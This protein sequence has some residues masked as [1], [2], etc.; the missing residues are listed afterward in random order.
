MT[1]LHF[2]GTCSPRSSPA[3]IL[4]R[5]VVVVVM[6]A[7]NASADPAEAIVLAT[8]DA[9]FQDALGDALA[10]GGISVVPAGDV[11]APS[12]AALSTAS[13]ELADRVHAT[14]TV[15][16]IASPG[17]A[18]LVAYDRERDRILVRQLPYPTP[19]APLQ[20]AEAARTART[21][22]RALRVTPD[23]DQQP[24]L[25]EDAPAIRDTVITRERP[26]LAASALV[27][28]RLGAPDTD[29]GGGVALAWRP[30][31]LGIALSAEL[32]PNADVVTASFTG[33]VIDGAI[34]LLGRAPLRVAPRINVVPD[35]GI[36]VH[37]FRLHGALDTMQP[38]H[39]TRYDP[40]ARV[41]VAATYR[42]GNDLD[43]GLAVSVDCLL[44]RQRYQAGD[45][46]VL[47]IPRLQTL[48]G[49]IATLRVL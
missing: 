1:A 35:V 37:V 14:A 23:V 33:T 18:T 17:G 40:A 2:K 38:I 20:A 9:V 11:P 28:I 48:V 30:D 16:L 10:A 46:Q 25:V 5:A 26:L 42:I 43:V 21:M 6:V 31:R 4:V 7:T 29:V 47:V 3:R 13:R 12:L 32:G 22:L 34:A 24:P 36:A 15:W 27:G 8:S 19:L 39:V 41:G 44:D 49:V 45:Q